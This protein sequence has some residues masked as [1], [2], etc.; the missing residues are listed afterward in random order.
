[1]SPLS[2]DRQIEHFEQSHLERCGR[3]PEN[4]GFYADVVAEVLSLPACPDHKTAYSV[5]ESLRFGATRVLDMHIDDLQI[6]VVGHVDR[7]DVDALLWDPM[8]GGSGLLDLVCK[9]F[10][11]IVQIARDI[12]EKCPSACEASCIDCLQTFRNAF[13]HKALDRKVALE[14]LQAWGETLTTTHPI[15]AVQPT[16]EP[17]GSNQ[18]VNQAEQRL[19][20]LLK[21]AGFAEGV[22]GKQIHLDRVIGSSTP[23]VTY[24]PE[25]GG[26]DEA[27]YIY[28]DGLSGHLHGNPAT[29]AQD[30]II[31]SWL[32]NHGHEV[33]EIAVSD[34]ADAGEMTRHFRK[35]A[36]YLGAADLR[37]AVRTDRSWFDRAA[38]AA[39]SASRF[40]LKVVRPRPEERYVRCVPLV[41]LQ[42]AAGGFGSPQFIEEGQWDWV[43]INT[44]RRLTAGMFVAQVVGASMEPQI[45]NGAYCLFE[46]PVAGTRKGKVVLV[47]LLDAADPETGQRYTV[48][49]YE[50]EKAVSDDGTWRHV[51][52]T[53]KPNN[54]SF[55]PIV[56]T[57]D[58]EDSVRVV[59]ELVQV[60]G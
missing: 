23:D 30:T 37:E 45:P 49:R 27:V 29:A 42:A 17:A 8:P 54:P 31:R 5:L 13:Y 12:V 1:V 48:K 44:Q 4:V 2:S 18:P 33:I 10:G 25:D 21:A 34:L 58:D 50:S 52:I 22:W 57:S 36:G 32:R 15:P 20:H 19:R 24:I 16:Q 3:K 41:P 60:L 39:E 9:R 11:E 47:Q 14:R 43:E 55:E 6:L 28:L 53:L 56:L 51:K 38:R 26:D 40:V 7:D 59:A 46:A 35:L